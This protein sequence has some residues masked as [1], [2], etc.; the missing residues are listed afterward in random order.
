MS[1]AE[2]STPRRRGREPHL[3][4]PDPPARPELVWE[5]LKKVFR[6]VNRKGRSNTSGLARRFLEV[7][8]EGSSSS[9]SRSGGAW[10]GDRRL[11]GAPSRS[12]RPT[13]WMNER[14]ARTR[15]TT[16]ARS[17]WS[18]RST[19]GTRAAAS[20]PSC[21]SSV[22]HLAHPRLH[23]PRAGG[24]EQRRRPQVLPEARLLPARRRDLRGRGRSARRAL[25]PRALKKP[26]SR[27]R[28]APKPKRAPRRPPKARSGEKRSSAPPL[29]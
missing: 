13:N 2:S 11:R 29:K 15:S 8:E 1:K 25:P 16:C 6:D 14:C 23:P 10:S 3:R 12:P 21:S 17:S 19:P 26:R 24:R 9:S 18:S 7:Y 28:P 4:A 5:F 22:E 20:A 27:R